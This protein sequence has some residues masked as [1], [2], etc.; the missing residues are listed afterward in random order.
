MEG[1][2]WEGLARKRI[3]GGEKGGSGQVLEETGMIYR[4]SGI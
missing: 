3:E 4:G 1:R 2:R